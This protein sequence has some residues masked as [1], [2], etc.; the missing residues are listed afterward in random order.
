MVTY[1]QFDSGECSFML[2]PNCSL[3][4]AWMKRVFL[5]F[6]LCLAAVATY[7]AY[8]GAWLVLPFAGL[9]LL[10]LGI[11]IYAN[12]RWGAT[13]EQVSLNGNRLR[14]MRGRG[15]PEEV[16][17]LPRH[18][19]RI[20]LRKDPRGWYPS[21]LL[22]QCHG[23]TVE[24]GKALVESERIQLAEDLSARLSFHAGALRHKP[25]PIPEGLGTAEQK[26]QT[27]NLNYG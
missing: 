9:E 10:I 23:R 15:K 25:A 22:L 3:G 11:G 4:W 14:V 8:L 16:A 12:A 2:V 13:R 1:R 19:T 24:I 26:I 18:W 20:K 6:G 21:Q 17:C 5:F 27:T 7:F